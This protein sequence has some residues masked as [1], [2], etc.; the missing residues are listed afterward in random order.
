MVLNDLNE[1]PKWEEGRIWFFVSSKCL[2]CSSTFCEFVSTKAD[3]QGLGSNLAYFVARQGGFAYF[4]CSKNGASLRGLAFKKWTIHMLRWSLR[5]EFGKPTCWR[6]GFTGVSIPLT[7]T[8]DKHSLLVSCRPS[9]SS[10][11]AVKR[12]V[13]LELLLQALC[14]S[15]RAIE[16]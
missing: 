6:Q 13:T 3:I 1:G 11:Q 5:R 2:F 7:F 16:D 14:E 10:W 9:C 12:H 4:V 15:A 8:D